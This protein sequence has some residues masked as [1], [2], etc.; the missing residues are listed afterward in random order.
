MASL[1]APQYK[2]NTRAPLDLIAVID[3]LVVFHG[4]RWKEWKHV[5]REAEAVP[6]DHEIRHKPVGQNRQPGSGGVRQS[7]ERVPSSDHHEQ[8]W[9]GETP[10]SSKTFQG[11][12]EVAVDGIR[13]GGSTNLGGGLL[14]GGGSSCQQCQGFK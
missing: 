1:K 9:E 8:P 12:A 10:L 5:R 11:S 14:K 6:R 7:C 4:N 2:A 13:V 3:K